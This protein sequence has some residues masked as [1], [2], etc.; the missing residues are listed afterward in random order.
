MSPHAVALISK[1]GCV[2]MSASGAEVFLNNVDLFGFK[3]V[4][5]QFDKV[6]TMGGKFKTPMPMMTRRGPNRELFAKVS[7]HDPW[8][9]LATMGNKKH[10]LGRTE[11]IHSWMSSVTTWRRL[12]M[13]TCLQ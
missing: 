9:M 13:V 12:L 2:D 6:R 7:T 5:Y 3:V 10:S 8:L 1:R 11:A 4:E